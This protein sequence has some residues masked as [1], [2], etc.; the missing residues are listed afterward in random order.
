[1]FISFL[2]SFFI[3]I[4][5]PL[6]PAPIDITQT[7]G[8]SLRQGDATQLSTRFAK[9]IELVID[10]EKVDFSSVEATHAKLI[11][12]QFFRKYPPHKF[13]FVY[14]GASDRMRYS[15]GT[16]ETSGQNF[17]VYV[18]MRQ[19]SDQLFTINALHFKRE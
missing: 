12:R 19:S 3:W 6:T 5:S 14:Q 2:L 8:T 13:Q 1:M 7:V 4:S 16:Y 15:T 10:A 9:T 18:L 11:L 17:T